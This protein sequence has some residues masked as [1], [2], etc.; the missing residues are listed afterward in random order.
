MSSEHVFIRAAHSI[1][2]YHIRPVTGE[3]DRYRETSY[4]DYPRSIG[5]TTPA[6][7][8]RSSLYCSDIGKMINAPVL[9][10]NGD[11]PEGKVSVSLSF[12]LLTALN[13]R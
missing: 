12:Y 6:S 8:A 13:R 3:P 4:L 9:H 10:V 5:Y 11:Y 1:L 7:S 2:T